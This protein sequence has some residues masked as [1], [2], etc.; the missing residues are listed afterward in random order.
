VFNEMHFTGAFTQIEV[1]Q[2]DGSVVMSSAAPPAPVQASGIPN[3]IGHAD[4]NEKQME[5]AEKELR[6]HKTLPGRKKRSKADVSA[7][8]NISRSWSSFL[9]SLRPAVD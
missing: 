1:K 3:G 9:E 7:L 5:T 8:L 6:G 2:D 4:K